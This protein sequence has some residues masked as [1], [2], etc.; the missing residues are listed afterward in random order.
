MECLLYFVNIQVKK[1]KI[2]TLIKKKTFSYNPLVP[3]TKRF[4]KRCIKNLVREND[5]AK[6]EENKTE[7]KEQ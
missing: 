3:L 2:A 4:E 5:F 1:I 6:K 7:K